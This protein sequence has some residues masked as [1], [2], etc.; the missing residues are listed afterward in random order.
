MAINKKEA[1]EQIENAKMLSTALRIASFGGTG[2]DKVAENVIGAKYARGKTMFTYKVL[3][4]E[5]FKKWNKKKDIIS[6][7]KH[8]AFVYSG[9]GVN[10]AKDQKKI[11]ISHVMAEGASINAGVAHKKQLSAPFS[12]ST[13][14]L[15]PADEVACEDVK[16]FK[17]YNQLQS[18]LY[19]KNGKVFLKYGDI[20]HVMDLLT[21]PK[22][23]FGLDFVQRDQYPCDK[24]NIYDK[25]LMSKGIMI[26][27]LYQKKMFKKN[28]GGDN[29][30]DVMVGKYPKKIT[31]EYEMNLLVIKNKS[32]CKTIKR[33]FIEI[34]EAETTQKVEIAIDTIQIKIDTAVTPSQ[35]RYK[36]GYEDKTLNFI[37][38]FEYSKYKYKK[39]DMSPFIE[40]LDEP[41]FIIH[42][43]T[44]Y[45]H[46]SLEGKESVNARL[47]KQRSESIVKSME[48]FQNKDIEEKI[49]YDDSW[50]MFKKQVQGTKYEYL[51]SKTK[52]EVKQ[53]LATNRKARRDLEPILSEE[54]F[55]RIV[56]FVTVDDIQ[57]MQEEKYLKKI[58][59][60]IEEDDFEKALKA[61]R[62][63]IENVLEGK[64]EYQNDFRS[65]VTVGT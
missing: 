17:Y 23:G 51:A 19:V 41:H 3:L 16:T 65:G 62:F 36:V 30:L 48:A 29:G 53:V 11:F 33:S 39:E 26:K 15:K 21:E 24:D 58:N 64:Y 46:S 40:A 60:A 61:Q 31:G 52:A 10:F 9:I 59:K 22:D 18:G 55:A 35:Q 13:K 50:N 63:I 43:I 1:V 5:I 8:S 20:N 42:K 28:M 37:I 32:I 2:S 7:W 12:K 27:P 14:G 34:K 4:D 38:P 44:F 45:A 6:S 54:R 56:M 49:I 47:R 25:T 57:G